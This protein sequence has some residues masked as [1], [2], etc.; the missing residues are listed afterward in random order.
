MRNKDFDFEIK[1]LL[2]N[3]FQDK[4]IKSLESDREKT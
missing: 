4:L 1:P 2:S 3:N